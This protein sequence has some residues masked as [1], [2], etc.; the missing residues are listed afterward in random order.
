M[1]GRSKMGPISAAPLSDEDLDYILGDLVVPQP[2]TYRL[3]AS[4][5]EPGEPAAPVAIRLSRERLRAALATVTTFCPSQQLID[6][7]DPHVRAVI[8]AL[9]R[10]G[11]DLHALAVESLTDDLTNVAPAPG[12]WNN[13][14]LAGYYLPYV[15]FP[16]I[17]S[18]APM[19][20][21]GG[22]AIQFTLRALE[23]LGAPMTE[24]G[25]KDAMEA[26][27]KFRGVDK[28]SAP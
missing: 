10:N 17:T 24:E 5:R 12:A 3:V 2:D 11:R 23:K 28:S 16:T 4:A 7:L 6:D 20:S 21:V 14:F 22:E 19:L 13:R 25:I 1:S 18:R 9:R 26:M 27:E 8:E 15:V